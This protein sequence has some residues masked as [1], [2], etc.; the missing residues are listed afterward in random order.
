MT[1]ARV[2]TIAVLVL[3]A[4]FATTAYGQSAGGPET[5]VVRNGP[6]TL[7]AL[8]WRPLGRGP[9]PAI[10]L[11]HGSDWHI[12][13]TR[14]RLTCLPVAAAGSTMHPGGMSD[15]PVQVL[16]SALFLSLIERAPQR[17]LAEQD[18]FRQA[19]LLNRAHPSVRQGVRFGL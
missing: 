16:D 17:G 4:G 11:N 6:I 5:V 3:A 19:F 8:L 1:K 14:S 18:Q 15:S 7:H 13:T 10:L 9:F 12:L 2:S